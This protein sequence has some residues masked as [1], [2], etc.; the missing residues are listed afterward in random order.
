MLTAVVR[1][2]GEGGETVLQVQKENFDSEMKS[3]AAEIAAKDRCIPTILNRKCVVTCPS[4]QN[5]RKSDEEGFSTQQPADQRC[6][7]AAVHLTGI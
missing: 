7:S 5:Y 1:V 4:T 2:R 3:R 6:V